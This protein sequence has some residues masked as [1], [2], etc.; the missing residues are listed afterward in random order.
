MPTDLNY[1]QTRLNPVMS[2]YVGPAAAAVGQHD[3]PGM[4]KHAHSLLASRMGHAD[5]TQDTLEVLSLIW[6]K[7]AGSA[8]LRGRH[9]NEV[10]LRARKI[11]NFLKEAPVKSVVWPDSVGEFLA[12]DAPA[13]TADECK[14]LNLAAAAAVRLASAS[15]AVLPP[16]TEDLGTKDMPLA[17]SSSLRRSTA[18]WMAYERAS[19]LMSWR[20]RVA[21]QRAEADRVHALAKAVEEA[22][23]RHAA[24]SRR[25]AAA[26][27]GTVPAGT[28][29]AAALRLPEHLRPSGKHVRRQRLPAT[30]AI[31]TRSP[32]TAKL[33]TRQV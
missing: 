10:Q 15:L 5:K 19:D 3:I 18:C 14:V 11:L 26:S 12:S 28:A 23:A 17:I 8:D 32:P 25:A 6:Q 13:T 27:A 21:T 33:A 4:V 1:R 16:R 7:R 31:G 22:E 30:R 29:S 9:A 20:R 24:A 2:F